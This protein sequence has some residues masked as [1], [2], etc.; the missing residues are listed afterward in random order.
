MDF[1]LSF[2][3]GLIG[4]LSPCI[5]PVIPIVLGSSLRAGKYGI[6]FLCFGLMLSF[7]ILGFF[8][9]SVGF[10][11]GLSTDVINTVGSI[12]IIICG[13]SISFEKIGFFWIKYLTILIQPFGK[14]LRTSQKNT[15]YGQFF[16]GLILGSIWSPCTGPTLGIAIVLAAKQVEFM[17]SLT[18]M[19]LYSFGSAIPLLLLGSLFQKSFS[20]KKNIYIYIIF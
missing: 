18:M 14:I 1:L 19:F 5:L 11:F 17:K 10:K 12:L 16:I 7:T 2:T 13:F 3:A 20:E 9:A 4:T 8:V 15:Y 6:L